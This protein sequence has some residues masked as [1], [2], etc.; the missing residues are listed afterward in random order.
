MSEARTGYRAVAY[1]VYHDAQGNEI[2]REE[3]AKSY[4][5]SAAARIEYNR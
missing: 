4:Y 2:K 3:L 1:R 5:K